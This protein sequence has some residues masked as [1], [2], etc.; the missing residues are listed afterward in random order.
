MLHVSKVKSYKNNIAEWN[1]Q[2]RRL[3]DK[4]FELVQVEEFDKEMNSFFFLFDDKV[5]YLMSSDMTWLSLPFTTNSKKLNASENRF[6]QI[7]EQ[8]PYWH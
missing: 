6:L 2:K 4:I 3:N 8:A 5:W 1:E 7:T